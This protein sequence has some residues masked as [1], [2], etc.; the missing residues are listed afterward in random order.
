MKKIAEFI[1][2]SYGHAVIC[3][4]TLACLAA[5]IPLTGMISSAALALTALVWG[6]QRAAVVLL[7][8]T[9]VLLGIF[10]LASNIGIVVAGYESVFLFALLQW[11]P[12]LVISQLLRTTRSLSF[13]LNVLLIF[14]LLVVVLSKFL[15]PESIEL[16]D[17]FFNWVLQGDVAQKEAND[18]DFSQYYRDFLNV[19]TGVAMASL[20]LVWMV[21]LLLARWW[22]SLL[23]QPGSFRSEFVG[24]EL[25]KVIAI[26]GFVLFAVMIFSKAPLTRE[27]LLVMMSAFLFQGI[28][29]VHC[30]LAIRKA[31]GWLLG[32][33]IALALSPMVPQVPGFLSMLGAFENLIRLRARVRSK[34]NNERG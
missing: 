14:G 22:Q 4:S 31:Q 16:W 5:F 25:G 34:I 20:I 8:S 12:I 24:L 10:V 7:L 21:S 19:M 6:T 9:A 18:P 29:T 11:L 3:V 13:T 33:Y 30:L 23:N 27:L 26:G 1:L 15:V 32:F 2:S 17:R 28:A